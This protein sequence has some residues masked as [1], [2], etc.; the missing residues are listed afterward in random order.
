MLFID[1]LMIEEELVTRC[2]KFIYVNLIAAMISEQTIHSLFL[3][4]NYL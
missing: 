2:V 1:W 4:L 3:F